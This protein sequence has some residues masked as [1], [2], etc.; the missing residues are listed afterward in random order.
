LETDPYNQKTAAI[1]ESRE[2]LD[3]I[4]QKHIGINNH[5]ALANCRKKQEDKL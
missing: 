3:T 2:L 1:E 4:K 5:K